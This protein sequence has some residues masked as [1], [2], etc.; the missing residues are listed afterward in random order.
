[1]HRD[2]KPENVVVGADGVARNCDFGLTEHVGQNSALGIGSLPYLAPEL[3]AG[4]VPAFVSLL[5]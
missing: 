2:I 3:F 4:E 1:M 5:M